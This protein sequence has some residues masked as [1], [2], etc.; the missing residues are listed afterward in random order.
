ME[1][2]VSLL[3]RSEG[4]CMKTSIHS[5]ISSMGAL[6][7]RNGENSEMHSSIL[8]LTSNHT[9]RKYIHDTDKHSQPRQNN[10]HSLHTRPSRIQHTTCTTN[11][12]HT[13]HEHQPKILGLTRPQTY[14][15]QTNRN[16]NNKSTQDNTGPA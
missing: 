15:Q 7:V 11:R 12:H 5:T 4:E 10:M 3:D 6:H 9:Y 1:S 2:Q 16:H 14:I 13:P 8:I